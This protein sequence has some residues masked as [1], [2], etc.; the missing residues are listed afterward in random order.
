[1]V[2][3][4]TGFMPDPHTT[5]GTAGG[6][7]NAGTFDPS[8]VGSIP[9]AA[10]HTM[11]LGTDFRNLRIMVNSSADTTLV[12]RGPDGRFRCNDD[13]G[14]GFRPMVSGAWGPG[15]YQV[16]VGVYANGAPTPYTIGFSELASVTASSLPLP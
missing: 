7:V 14:G 3:L 5:T 10:Q 4:R 15:S 9:S 1:M 11:M 6:P 2:N 13:G 16:W 8:C 12:I